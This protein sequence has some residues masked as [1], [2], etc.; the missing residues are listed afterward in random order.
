MLR[1]SIP[2]QPRVLHPK[3]GAGENESLSAVLGNITNMLGSVIER[4]DKTES[5]L[6]SMERKIN[7]PSSSA[8]SGADKKKVPTVVRVS[9]YLKYTT[10]E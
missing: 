10:C 8:G 3:S 5:K 2:A 7:S 6:E 4:L 9:R 1:K